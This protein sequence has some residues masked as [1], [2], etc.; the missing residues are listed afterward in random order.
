MDKLYTLEE[1]SLMLKISRQTLYNWRRQG[2]IK[3]T[4]VNGV[5]RI[6]ESELSKI[7]KEDGEE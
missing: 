5:P 4:K 7:I 3:F 2:K 1:A 6:S